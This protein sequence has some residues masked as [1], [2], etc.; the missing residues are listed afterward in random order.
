MDGCFAFFLLKFEKIRRPVLSRPP[1]FFHTKQQKGEL[2]FPQAF[3]LTRRG[4]QK[5]K[6]ACRDGRHAKKPR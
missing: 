6:R 3:P 1:D 2:S 5:K 4:N